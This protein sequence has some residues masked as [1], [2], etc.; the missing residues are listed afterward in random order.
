MYSKVD[1][2]W[3]FIGG[4]ISTVH[5]IKP[6]L[7]GLSQV[8]TNKAYVNPIQMLLQICHVYPI[9]PNNG[10]SDLMSTRMYLYS[11]DNCP[12]VCIFCCSLWS[13]EKKTAAA[14]SPTANAS[15]AASNAISTRMSLSHFH[16][17]WK[18][19]SISFLFAA[20]SPALTRQYRAPVTAAQCLCSV[21]PAP[22]LC[23][24][25]ICERWIF[26]GFCITE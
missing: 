14:L 20:S 16:Q 3:S 24:Y 23:L 7:L 12:D 17:Y 1:S 5:V 8:T 9:N 11:I 13:P 4:S 6:S 25:M 18:Y 10:F 22:L 15:S 26:G 19:M 2:I 21:S